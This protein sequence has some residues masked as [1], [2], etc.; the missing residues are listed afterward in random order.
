MKLFKWFLGAIVGVAML[1]FAATDSNAQI[2]AHYNMV[3]QNQF[4]NP[5]A[6]S[7]TV[8]DPLSFKT[9]TGVNDLDDGV[10]NNIPTGF[11]FDFNGNLY[12]LVNV[13]INGWM[14][15]GPRSV[16]TITHDK[17]YLFQPNEP[18]NT[19]APFWGDHYY[20]TLADVPNGY[21]PTTIQYVTNAVPD[22]NP[23]AYP[24][25]FL[26]TFI[27][28]WKDLNIND[29]T[30][31]NS[32]ATFQVQIVEN[33]MA[34][35]MSV[36]DKRATIQFHYGPIGNQGNVKTQGCTVG[37]EDSIGYSFMNGLFPSSFAGGDSTRLDNDSLTT[38]WPPASCLPGRI[39]TFQIQGKGTLSQWG[40]GDADLTQLTSSDPNV[41]NNQNRFV[42]LA[43]ADLILGST[44]QAYPPMDSVEGR[45][46]FHGDCNHNGRYQIPQF[47]PYYFYRVTPYDAA[48]ILTYLAAKIP[49]LPWVHVLP[50]WKQSAGA[51]ETNIASISA[52]TKQLVANDRTVLVP[53]VLH[54]SVNGPVSLECNV[55]SL[56]S[57]TLQFIGTQT[58][59]GMIYGNAKT[60]K[61]AFAAAGIFSE[62][63]VLGYLEFVTSDRSASSDIELTNIAINDEN[64]PSQHSS[65]TMGVASSTTSGL[66]V[67]KVSPNP[68][69][70]STDGST[71]IHFSTNES[72]EVSLKIYDLLG[73]EVRTVTSGVIFGAGEHSIQWDGHDNTGSVV[74]AGVYYYNLGSGSSTLV[75]KIN[76]MQ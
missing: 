45:N 8:I 50:P 27:V 49:F 60:G 40:D 34:N 74:P 31:P 44:A 38:C 18:N 64:Y 20:R 69:S 6:G 52:D 26:H 4:Y 24:G 1:G 76:L 42:T 63:D 58:K 48:Y 10:S 7:P 35:D 75:G 39:I 33:P 54:G 67:E 16:P 72:Q 13:C 22:P 70:V 37:I 17:Y 25:S 57:S 5:L 53:L 55:K 29:K 66:A 46:A 19:L 43:D 28:E 73:K 65:L 47:L 62:G 61:V 56:N 71:A 21:K 51:V 2:W 15:V 32:I 14:S 30:N 23:N 12:G 3:V 11:T 41:V 36:P 9:F 68:F 59:T